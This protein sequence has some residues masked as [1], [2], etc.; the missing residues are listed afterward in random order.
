MKRPITLLAALAAFAAQAAPPV[1]AQ[2]RIAPDRSRIIATVQFFHHEH[3]ST[4]VRAGIHADTCR[5]GL[6]VLLLKTI[7]APEAEAPEPL[8]VLL[9]GDAYADAVA[10]ALCV[11]LLNTPRSP[12]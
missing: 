1:V 12:A 5:A 7:T 2:A 9:E 3:G 10:R 6:G 4:L 8:D 11:R